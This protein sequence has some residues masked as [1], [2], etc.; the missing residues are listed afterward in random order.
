MTPLPARWGDVVPELHVDAE[1][2]RGLDGIEGFSHVLVAVPV[3]GRAGAVP[4]ATSRR[5]SA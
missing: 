5:G 2:A 1:L 4:V 3:V